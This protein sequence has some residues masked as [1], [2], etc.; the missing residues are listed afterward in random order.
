M[1]KKLIL[2]M[3]CVYV[4]E[5]FGKDAYNRHT[6]LIQILVTDLVFIHNVDLQLH[7][8]LQVERSMDNLY[9]ELL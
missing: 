3:L 6:I 5:V 8:V 7:L 1:A 2:Y 9:L 4:Q